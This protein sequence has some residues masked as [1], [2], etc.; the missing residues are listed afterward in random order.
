MP[1]TGNYASGDIYLLVVVRMCGNIF[2]SSTNKS[3]LL[4]LRDKTF[5]RQKVKTSTDSQGLYL[6]EEESTD[7]IHHRGASV[8]PL[9]KEVDTLQDLFNI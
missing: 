6:S 2:Q 4:D 9:L 1:A 8:N 5:Q 7:P 3:D